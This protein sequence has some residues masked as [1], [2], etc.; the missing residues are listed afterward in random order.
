MFERLKLIPPSLIIF[1]ILFIILPS[2]IAFFI[3]ISL[4]NKILG[5]TNDV[6]NNKSEAK[7]TKIKESFRKASV[8]L[9]LTNTLALLETFYNEQKMFGLRYDKWDYFC[10]SLPNL[11]VTFG[12]LGT[13]LGI[14]FNLGDISEIINQDGTSSSF[15]VGNLKAPLQSMS[16]AFVSSLAAILFSASLTVV[17]FICNTELAKNNLFNL[18]ENYL[19]N[20]YFAPEINLEFKIKSILNSVL[21][22]QNQET[23]NNLEQLLGKVLKESLEPFSSTLLNSATI[24]QN[25]VSTLENQ[26]IVISES[27]TSLKEAS[28]QVKDGAATFHI[29]SKNIERNGEN[30]YNLMIDLNK[31]QE[32]FAKSTEILQENVKEIIDNNKR[33]TNLAEKTYENLQE[34]AKKLEDSSLGFME[35][36][37]TIKNSQ[38]ADKLLQASQDLA[39]TQH[40]FAESATNLNN[41]T[42][43]I[44]AIAQD[45][46]TSI[47]QIT[48]LG[49]DIKTLNQQSVEIITLNQQRLVTEEEK[50]N[51]IQIEL[52][53]LIGVTKNN[54]NQLILGIQRL[55]NNL[56]KQLGNN[57]TSLQTVS[58]SIQE[59]VVNLN[60]MKMGL[61][62]LISH[63]REIE[64][65]SESK[66]KIIENLGIDSAN[67]I[68]FNQQQ[69]SS[70][71]EK[72]GN[73]SSNLERVCQNIEQNT[74]TLQRT[75]ADFSQLILHF[76][77]LDN[78]VELNELK[79]IIK[80]HSNKLNTIL[81]RLI[82]WM[83]AENKKAKQNSSN[84]YED[85]EKSVHELQQINAQLSY[86]TEVTSNGIDKRN[87]Q[88]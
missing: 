5:I 31:N 80:A 78:N 67:L 70:I 27:A 63:I 44:N 30:S 66:L 6:A 46:H 55:G 81:T 45:F 69:L 79:I 76:D 12:L 22:P 23:Q 85:M 14:T 39:I 52:F 49:E 4:Y 13:F 29:A 74:D 68:K 75:Q 8:G 34:S 65:Q 28:Q 37:E 57:S 71:T 9:K 64:N 62:T 40:Q 1:I 60:N 50:L 16:I 32:A 15:V 18:L 7:I 59:Y 36:S 43:T 72:L 73:N 41:S 86:L 58:Q 20:D 42:Q 24:F 56:N 51:N 3:R 10:K 26:V 25:A 21:Y 87:N 2:A 84:L 35:A 82:Q 48:S 47:N 88:F 61:D 54:Q 19:D 77:K 17:N 53:K 11:L 33:A 38:F 83:V